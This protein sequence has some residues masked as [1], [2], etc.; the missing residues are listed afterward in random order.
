[1]IHTPLTLTSAQ[2]VSIV[3][4]AVKDGLATPAQGRRALRRLAHEGGD[5]EIQLRSGWTITVKPESLTC[6]CGKG[7]LCPSNDQS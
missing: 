3:A 6:D 4:Q 7:I 5:L 1:M 2:A